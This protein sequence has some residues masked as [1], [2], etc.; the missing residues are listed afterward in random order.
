[1]K[2]MILTIGVATTVLV[3]AGCSKP[4]KPDSAQSNSAPAA[5]TPAAS[6]VLNAPGAPTT[7][8]TSAD[9]T[10]AKAAGASAASG[11]SAATAT[12]ASTP[13][14]A[15]SVAS[16]IV[17]A[18]QSGDV[19]QIE[20]SFTTATPLQAQAVAAD[21]KLVA[22][23]NQVVQAAQAKLGSQAT[24]LS[25]LV[26]KIAPTGGIF[27]TL[28]ALKNNPVV[29]QGE[30]AV[31]N[32]GKNLASVYFSKVAGNWKID[33]QKTLT[34]YYPDANT[35]ESK[36]KSMTSGFGKATDFLKQVQSGLHNGSITSFSDVETLA[37][38]FEAG[39]IPGL[40]KAKSLLHF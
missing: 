5:G 6:T 30:T 4:G 40:N 24:T 39:G 28:A 23:K 2:K 8:T 11:T 13:S 38:K 19:T 17:S 15:S 12:L 1:M 33:L 16:G 9:N 3:L 27:P 29:V 20:N 14:A 37:A 25:T 22:I 34:T 31:I 7:T 26:A 21:A 35:A 18:L 10:A 36:L 32:Q